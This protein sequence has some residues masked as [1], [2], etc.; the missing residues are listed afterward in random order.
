MLRGDEGYS[1]YELRIYRVPQGRE[2]LLGVFKDDRLDRPRPDREF[3]IVIPAG[4][5]EWVR[6]NRYTYK[7]LQA[8]SG[9]VSI[10]LA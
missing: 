5:K 8:G 7:A 9:A 1:A 3:R 10:E 2:L 4:F 6:L